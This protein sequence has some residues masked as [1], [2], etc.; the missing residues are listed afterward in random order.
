M[1]SRILILVLLCLGLSATCFAEMRD[2]PREFDGVPFGKSY[3]PG[4]SFS[5]Q[6]DSEE[7]VVCTRTGDDLQLHGVPIKS[8]TYQFMYKQLNT[9]EM[10]V[11][12]RENYDRLAAEIA[13]R[14]GTP[15]TLLGGMLSYEGKMVDILLYF[16]AN[17]H[18]GV[19]SYS[20]KY[21]PC[22]VE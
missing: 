14:H 4:K 15:V 18:M 10:E 8:R 22:A 6:T 1:T 19:V 7:A 16:D 20:L 5:C 3:E 12:G 13:K 11:A 9:V 21:P 17:R 2:E